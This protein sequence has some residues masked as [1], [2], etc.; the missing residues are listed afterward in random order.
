MTLLPS[1]PHWAQHLAKSTSP[2]YVLLREAHQPPILRARR[3]CL[4]FLPHPLCSQPV[5][6]QL[7]WA[8]W[9]SVPPIPSLPLPQSRPGANVPLPPQLLPWSQSSQ[10]CSFQSI[11]HKKARDIFPNSQ[12]SLTL[13]GSKLFHGSPVPSG[14]TR[15][16]STGQTSDH[17][18]IFITSCLELYTPSNP[19]VFPCIPLTSLSLVTFWVR[20]PTPLSSPRS[21]K[22]CG[23][24]RLQWSWRQLPFVVG[25][26]C[27][28]HSIS[29]L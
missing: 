27:A 9:L 10:F 17:C 21:R 22:V 13:T 5:P 6:G 16:P 28:K 12:L 8:S 29:I 26:L 24:N 3:S 7:H 19:T 18:L 2:L 14:Q 4:G 23:M 20:S 15:S 1:G 25:L 11:L